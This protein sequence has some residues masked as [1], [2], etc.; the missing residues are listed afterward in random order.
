M[1]LKLFGENK[2][3]LNLKNVNQEMIENISKSILNKHVLIVNNKEYRIGEIE[4]YI[5]SDVHND[6]YTHG[7]L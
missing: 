4:F 5:K 1:A 7:L 3:E 6:E 2:D